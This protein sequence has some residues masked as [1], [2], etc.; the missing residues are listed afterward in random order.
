MCAYSSRKNEPGDN[1]QL[2]SIGVEVEG[3]VNTPIF[4]LDRAHPGPFRFF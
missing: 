1:W 2:S 3:S 4:I